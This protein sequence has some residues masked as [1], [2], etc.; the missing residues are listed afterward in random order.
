MELLHGTGSGVMILLWVSV[1]LALYRLIRGPSLAD[2][3]VA[4]T[5]VGGSLI[6]V[7]T[8]GVA[9]ALPELTTAISGVR[10]K[11]HGISLGTL[12]G[13][14]ITN[15]LVSTYYVPGPLVLWDLPWET[16]T[17]AILWA[18][19]WFSKGRLNRVGAI[20]LMGLY[21]VYITLRVLFFAVD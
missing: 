20:Y 4:V 18:I 2:R 1:A 6:G 16:I 7:V 17:G 3:V 8:L 10:N 19:L 14:N 12:V 9:S 15:P 13:S 11:E 21:V 5:G